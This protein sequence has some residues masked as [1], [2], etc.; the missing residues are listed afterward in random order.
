[1]LR[2]FSPQGGLRISALEL[3]R[4]M[5]LHLNKG[6]FDG[7]RI[8]S[9]KSIKLMHTP[10][11][12]WNGSNGDPD[13]GPE[14]SW[15]LSVSILTDAHS[16]SL[17]EGNSTIMGHGG[18]AYGLISKFYFDPDTKSGLI[19]IT[20][21]LFDAPAKSSSSVFYDFEEAIFSAARQNSQF[22]CPKK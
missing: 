7:K 17:P 16:V 9:K 4:V 2:Y 15:G 8:I 18:D 12:T 13:V 1:M 6:T 22:R 14:R 11:W 21:G 19:L 5:M 3:A 20:N 10:Q